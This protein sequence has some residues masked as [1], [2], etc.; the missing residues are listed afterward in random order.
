MGWV[1]L[2]IASIVADQVTKRLVTA[3]THIEI[4]KGFFY[5]TYVENRGAAFS[6]LQNFR[7]GFVILTFIAFAVMIRMMVVQKHVLV[8]LSLSLLIGG[9]TGNLI[10]RLFHGYVVDFLDFYPFGYDFP[11]F[12]AADVCI[13]VGVA[14][15]IIYVVFIYKEPRKEAET[16]SQETISGE[17]SENGIED[18]AEINSQEKEKAGSTMP[19]DS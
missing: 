19:G 3:G 10:D 9:A 5:I 17:E 11:V 15:L 18:M 6:I 8:R 1:L 14:L 16:A 4:I 7:W 12:N 2:I 13:T